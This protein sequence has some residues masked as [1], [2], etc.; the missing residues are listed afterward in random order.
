MAQPAALVTGSKL[1]DA[2]PHNQT[3]E[4]VLKI[5]SDYE[6]V[7]M[8]TSTPSLANDVKCAEAIK[9]QNRDI[10]IGFIGAHVAVLPEKNFSR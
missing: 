6:L 1:I 10:V 5:A 9:A 8:H 4:D 7:I 2:P 3:V